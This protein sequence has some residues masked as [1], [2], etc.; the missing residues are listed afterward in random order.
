MLLSPE[1]SATVNALSLLYRLSNQVP[2][3]A[4]GARPSLPRRAAPEGWN[5][6]MALCEA[7][8]A[9][10]AKWVVL[11]PADRAPTACAGM[12][13]PLVVKVLPSEAE[14]KSELGLVKL[15]VG[16]A[17]EVDSIAAD[18]RAKLGKPSAG[19]LVQEM[20]REGVEVV[21]S[22][23]RRTDFGPILSIGSGGVAI[24]LYR[25]IT[26]LALP[27]SADQVRAALRKLKLWT[28]LQGFRG[29]PAADVDAL[30]DCAVR[31]GD[32]LVSCP[33]ITEFELNPV[34]VGPSGTG[35]RVVDALVV[36][37]PQPPAG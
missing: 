20:A 21:L 26:H 34:I 33:E 5:E 32:V 12:R 23:L 13:F 29:K 6:T 17:A 27:V 10:P 8:G 7:A 25:D 31:L 22:F 11:G 18:F 3:P 1:P 28:L 9:T 16:S 24:E 37:A 2:A 4:A 14:H 36:A 35:L 15:R 19:I 30:V